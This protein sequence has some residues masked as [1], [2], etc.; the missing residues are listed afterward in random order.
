M[1][2][3]ADA[4]DPAA[5]AVVIP[6]RDEADSLRRLLPELRGAL[7]SLRRPCEII[8]VDDGSRDA[9]AGVVADAA[10]GPGPAVR[11]VRT[12]PC[13]Q[14]AAM[15]AGVAAT[16]AP[17]IA[18]LDADGQNDPAELPRLL[19]ELD[20]HAV[21]LVQGDRTATRCDG[22]HRR[23][24]SWIGRV[25]RRLLLGDPTRDTGCTL[26]VGRR[27]LLAAIPLHETGMHRF[28]PALVAA[29]GGRVR[30][31]PV[32]HRPRIGGRTHYRAFGRGLAG[33]RGC[34]RVLAWRA[35]RPAGRTSPAE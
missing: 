9:T 21:D 18:F 22:V 34:R 5:L 20:R 32:T 29:A 25:A 19:A 1:I 30:E 14:S 35:A 4:S 26:R 3:H 8:V 31:V 7:E 17:L 23:L 33:L 28:I 12:P 16:A 2:R 27:D 13:G 24:A 10:A 15:A 6:A 11:L